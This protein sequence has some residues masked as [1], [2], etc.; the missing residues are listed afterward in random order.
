MTFLCFID[1]MTGCL[2]GRFYFS[3]YLAWGLECW[4][5]DNELCF[6]NRPFSSS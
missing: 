5:E 6:P 1:T 2:F 4:N 3:V